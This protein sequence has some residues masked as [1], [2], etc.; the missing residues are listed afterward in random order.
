MDGRSAD[1]PPGQGPRSRPGRRNP[2]TP[3][4]R[5]VDEATVE[6]VRAI[7]RPM[8]PRRDLLIE[9]LHKVQDRIGYLHA[10]HLAA[11]AEIFRLSQ[12][13][14]HSVASFYHHFDIVKEGALPPPPVTLRICDGI[15]CQMAGAAALTEAMTRAS[16]PAR[17]RVQSVP[18]IG[19]CDGAPAAHIGRRAVDRAT[20]ELLTA[21][22][23]GPTTPVVADY[24][25]LDAY[26]ASGGY[27]AL[28]K[29]LAGEIDADAAIAT[30]SDAKLRG[31]GGAGFPAGR[32]WGFVRGYPGPRLM[33]INGDE[34]EP[35][36]FKDR[37]WLER[38]PHRMFEG[39]LIA[40][41][42]VEAERIYLYMRDE[43]QGVLEILRREIAA[44]DAAG[45]THVPI[46]L[47]RGAGAYICGEESAM[48]E[49]IEGKRGLPRH[50]PPYIAEVGL[51]GRPTLNHNIETL[52]WIPTILNDGA[53]A[54]ASQGWD[55]N[56]AGLRS[57]S[58]SG[59]VAEPGV[60]LAP[61]GIPVRRLI[62]DY[63][64]GMAPGHVFKAFLPGGAS[65]GILPASM[66]DL[67]LDFGTF[68]KHGGFVGS[69]AVVILSDQDS[70]HDVA[71]NLMRFFRNESCGQCTPCR[72][73]TDKMVRML[74]AGGL[75]PSLAQDLM[76]V[77]RD[78][79]ICGLGQAASNSVAHLLQHF[80]EDV[81]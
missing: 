3:K 65:G 14:V 34:G 51:F 16:D 13:E 70:V 50:R 5:Q 23:A 22:L 44:L 60:K 72:S 58:V 43:Y 26:R 12:A 41:K 18:C 28:A 52:L 75:D 27:R 46:E 6:D 37:Y 69:H 79:S 45:L 35:G 49:S 64:G 47:R 4:G 21:G 33:T 48:I 15:A 25:R 71:V 39:A 78:S 11:I 53:A 32:K 9:A 2:A 59:R 42:I 57:F 76:V 61:A 20:P 24:E 19:R 62:A 67:P 80:P 10:R 30:M 77:M 8:P 63:C 38:H 55:E 73:G 1:H 29:V 56:H 54:F 31:L 36:T 66:G 68:E 74:E 7:L 17:V 81:L 40:A